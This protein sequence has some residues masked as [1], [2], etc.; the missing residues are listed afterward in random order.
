MK[1]KKL[2]DSGMR[3]MKYKRDEMS[4]HS[5]E[6]ISTVFGLL[7]EMNRLHAE[8]EDVWEEGADAG[9]ADSELDSRTENPY[10][11]DIVR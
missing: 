5:S 3:I 11:K 1:N 8:K 2:Y 10:K 4:L 7:L 6:I 9:C